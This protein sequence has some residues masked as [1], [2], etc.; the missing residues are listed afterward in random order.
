MDDDQYQ[1]I[2]AHL[3]KFCEACALREQFIELGVMD[4]EHAKCPVHADE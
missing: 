1:S 4:P 2:I 3:S